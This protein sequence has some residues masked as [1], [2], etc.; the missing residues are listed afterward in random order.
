[1]NRKEELILYAAWYD[2]EN[3]AKEDKARDGGIP[4]EVVT[5]KTDLQNRIPELKDSKFEIKAI[6]FECKDKKERDEMWQKTRFK[7]AGD[8]LVSRKGDD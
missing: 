2:D 8:Y 7:I 6:V 4:Y 3:P 1:M 5:I